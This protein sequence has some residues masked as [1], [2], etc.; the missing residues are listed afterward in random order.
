MQEEQQRNERNS[1]K[2]PFDL[3]QPTLDLV[4]FRPINLVA[5]HQR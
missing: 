1:K 4:L 3:I 2:L 5:L